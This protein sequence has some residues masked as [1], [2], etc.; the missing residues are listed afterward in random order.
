MGIARNDDRHGRN[1]QLERLGLLAGTRALAWH[2]G[3]LYAGR[4]YA[5]VRRSRIMSRSEH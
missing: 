4:G 3:W 1:T 2:E 5:L